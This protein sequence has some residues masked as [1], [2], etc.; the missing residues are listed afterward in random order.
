[1]V[2][3]IIVI[4]VILLLFYND[5]KAGGSIGGIGYQV[6]REDLH[7][8]FI[9]HDIKD[10]VF[11]YMYE[12]LDCVNLNSYDNQDNIALLADLTGI[13]KPIVGKPIGF[14]QKSHK[15]E[16]LFKKYFTDVEKKVIEDKKKLMIISINDARKAF[17]NSVNKIRKQYD[18]ITEVSGVIYI[19]DLMYDFDSMLKNLIKFAETHEPITMLKRDWH[20]YMT[21][22]G[23]SNH[24]S[25]IERMKARKRNAISPI[26]SWKVNKELIINT[27]AYEENIYEAFATHSKI[28]NTFNPTIMINCAKSYFINL[29]KLK[30]LDPSLGWSDRCIASIAMGCQEFVAFDP[31]FEL[32]SG[33]DKLVKGRGNYKFIPEPF[34]LKPKY[35]NYFDFVFSSSPF[36]DVEIYNNGKQSIN[37]TNSYAEWIDKFYKQYL[38][39]A[40]RCTAPG[41]L[42]A[43]YIEDL[44]ELT[45][46]SDTCKIMNGLG[47]DYYKDF[48]FIQTE[49]RPC[50]IK[51]EG[52]ERK[53]WCW[54]K[55]M[56]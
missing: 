16:D 52:K 34:L 6:S 27:A 25:G 26:E 43:F 19:P 9:K 23:L 38:T 1:M 12:E 54:T 8:I 5:M 45:M 30:V 2:I 14:Q 51:K 50:G 55:P 22:D 40:Y 33:F 11:A 4:V 21:T 15:K 49:T 36:Y 56:D 47:A 18:K 24:Y 13:Y 42:I 48:G 53:L 41:G 37:E 32:K 31:N 20:D 7:C 3:I 46:G 17:V 29:K 28:C 44:G 39:D 10:A 35:E